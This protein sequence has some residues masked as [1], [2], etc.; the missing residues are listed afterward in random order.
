[1]RSKGKTIFL[2]THYMEEAERLC[3][4]VA[5]IDHGKI[6]ALNTPRNLISSY[7]EEKAIQF[8][9]ESPPSD[10]VLRRLDGV[11]NVI[12]DGSDVVLYSSSIP[13]TMSALLQFADRQ[14]LTDKLNDL[15]IRQATLEDVFL[16]LTGRKIRE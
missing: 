14:N 8:E 10:D 2:T 3:E 11:N 16:K 4:R 7:F 5:I 15:R 12:I 6:I 1:M 9:M 13:T